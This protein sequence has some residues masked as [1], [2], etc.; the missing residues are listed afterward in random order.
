MKKIFYILT[1]FVLWAMTFSSCDYL[2]I[3]PDEIPT[4]EDAFKDTQALLRYLYSCYGYIP[5]P[6]HQTES[7]DLFTADEVISGAAHETFTHFPEGN[8]SAST[9]VISYWNTLFTG[10][11]QCYLLLDNIEMVPGVTQEEI[12]NYSAEATFLIAYYHFLLLRSYGPIMIIDRLPD[13]NMPV[14]QYPGRKPYDEC[15]QW[16]ADKFDEAIA[17]G[18]EPYQYSDTRFYGRATALAAKA[19]KSRILLYAASPLFNG[20]TAL[21][22]T[23]DATLLNQAYA[24]FKNNGSNEQLISTTYSSEKWQKAATAAK[25]AIEDAESVGY[26][27]AY[28]GDVREEIDIMPYPDNAVE[29]R[30]RMTIINNQ[31]REIIWAD[32]R[33]DDLNYGLQNKSAPTIVDQPKS[34]AWNCIAPT[35]TMVELFYTSNGLP[36]D[37]DPDWNTLKGGYD[38]RYGYSAQENGNGTTLNLNQNREPRFEAWIAYH[39]SYYE[40]NSKGD[41]RIKTLFRAKDQ[42]GTKERNTNYSPTGYLNK[43]GVH[44]LN[45][46]GA[47]SGGSTKN[48]PWSVIRLAELYLNYA[49]ALIEVGGTE[50]L[51]TA[52]DYID[53]VRLRA[54]IPTI[55]ASWSIV[56]PSAKTKKDVMREIVRQ[57]RSVELYMENHRFWDVRRWMLGTKYFN[58]S[59]RGMNIL[60]ATN[61]VFFQVKEINALRLFVAPKNYLMPMPLSD[62]NKN[63]KLVQ[64]PGY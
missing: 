9:P 20:Q 46:K 38:G 53:K 26:A 15:V 6:R 23:S 64:N 7:L 42:Q 48:Y 63:Q 27:L 55:E 5:N 24:E 16:I 33:S 59:V 62:L 37:K 39:N 17:I 1:V 11:R 36:I 10:I 56:D 41:Y 50:N 44:P 43:K 29:R 60:G 22:A 40:Y 61:A 47:E 4:E 34:G 52:A 21:D 54:G 3:V 45:S 35:L 2:D 58:A 49:E 28:E 13:I 30:L 18:L 32:T 31:S 14:S 25:A 8:Y 57:E 51:S 19:I 12:K